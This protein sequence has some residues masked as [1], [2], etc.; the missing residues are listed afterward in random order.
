MMKH[1]SLNQI[2]LIE[3]EHENL[4][5]AGMIVS[6]TKLSELAPRL[7]KRERHYSSLRVSGFNRQAIFWASN[8]KYELPWLE[9]PSF[10]LAKINSSIFIPVAHTLN[11]PHKWTTSIIDH[12]AKT[13][14]LALPLLFL[15]SN[16][17]PVAISLG[18]N[19]LPVPQ[20]DWS[21]FMHQHRDG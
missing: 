20:V 13:N 14:A 6:Y 12:L 11:L 5:P 15:P 18:K 9:N 4:K 8:D 1:H 21:T 16:I 2:D 19:S 10:Y 17:K 3:C 7:E